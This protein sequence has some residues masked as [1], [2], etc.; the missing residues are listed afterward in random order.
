MLGVK[1]SYGG[2]VL[3]RNEA[4]SKKLELYQK[5]VPEIQEA[6]PLSKEDLPS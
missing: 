1:T 4:E 5:Y 3:V 2:A 6:L